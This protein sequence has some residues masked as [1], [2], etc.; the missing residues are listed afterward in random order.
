MFKVNE[1]FDGNVKSLGFS[2]SDGR[3]TVGV[4]APGSYIF[5]TNC[6]EEMTLISGSMAV[7]L[8]GETSL[9]TIAIGETFTVAAD[10]K[11]EV[12]IGEQ[13]A[14]LCKYL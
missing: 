14:Y 13:A 5:G 11:F 7:I 6:V 3:F 8:P 10:V 2:N 12:E 9:R 1:Y 4:M